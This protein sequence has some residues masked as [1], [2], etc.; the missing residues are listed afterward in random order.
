MDEEYEDWID[1]WYTFW[2]EEV[3]DT[4]EW[5]RHD[6]HKDI[7]KPKKK[8]SRREHFYRQGRTCSINGDHSTAIKFYEEALKHSYSNWEKCEM[9]CIIADEYE[10]VGDYASAESY[11]NRAC[12]AAQYGTD[13]IYLSRK[14]E[15]L[16]R[17]GRYEEAVATYEEALESIDAVK[18][19]MLDSSILRQY[20]RITHF[21]IASYDGLSRDSHKERYHDKVRRTIGRY[22]R[23]VRYPS[24]EARADGLCD[25]AWRAYADDRLVDEALIFIDSAIEIHPNCPADYYNIKAIILNT[26]F[27]YDEALKCYDIALSKD[28]TN[29]TFLENKADCMR[30][31]LKRKLF[32]KR[33]ESRDLE[34]INEALKILPEGCDNGPY[35]STKAE[36]LDQLGEGVKARICQALGAKRYD[37][38]DKAEKQL[39]KLKS[40]ETYINITGT[41]YYKNFAPFREGTIVDLIRESDNPHDRHAIRVEIKGETVG[42]V[43]NNQYTLIKE[44]K[45]A[46]DLKYVKLTQAEVQFILFNEW[47]IAKLIRRS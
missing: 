14:G 20:A 46:R 35:L 19:T 26:G 29:K 11:L 7:K 39:K 18:D 8:I 36:I 13:Y 22:V 2:Y 17:M 41:Q 43:A 4:N 33:T 3:W 38:A 12:E 24:D 37:E 23:A 21:I 44:V 34:V 47:V 45:S 28:P 16:Y 15:F 27:Q 42:Y 30:N 5:P 40:S 1:E 6:E 9:L 31:K 10:T 25:M 32:F